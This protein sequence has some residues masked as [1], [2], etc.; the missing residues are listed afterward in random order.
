MASSAPRP[1]PPATVTELVKLELHG[2]VVVRREEQVARSQLERREMEEVRWLTEILVMLE[3]QRADHKAI[4]EDEASEQSLVDSYFLRFGFWHGSRKKRQMTYQLEVMRRREEE[5]ALRRRLAVERF[6]GAVDELLRMYAYL[7]GGIARSE[8]MAWHLLLEEADRSRVQVDEKGGHQVVVE[9]RIADHKRLVA[10]KADRRVVE[11]TELVEREQIEGAE[12][13]L[14]A[15]LLCNMQHEQ[16]VI[17]VLVEEHLAF[18]RLS[19]A[20]S[21][22]TAVVKTILRNT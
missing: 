16:G 22:F 2:R 10:E 6:N 8:E 15:L 18:E 20:C 3:S 11:D 7:F 9:A 21:E 19:M 14:A 12:D 5:V 1:P 4:T 13:R 17:P